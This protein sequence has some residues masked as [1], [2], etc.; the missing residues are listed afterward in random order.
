MKKIMTACITSALIFGSSVSQAA[1]LPEVVGSWL[2]ETQI[3]ANVRIA[4]DY[5]FY[6]ASQTSGAGGNKEGTSIQG[7]FDITWATLSILG[8][9]DVYSG[10]FAANTEWSRGTNDPASLEFTHYH[11]IAGG[12]GETGIS[13]DFGAIQYTYPNQDGDAGA[14]DD[15]DYWEYYGNF[16]YTFSDIM[17]E[18]SLGVGYYYSPA[19]FGF[20]DE[21][22]HV[23]VTLDLSLPHGFGINMFFGH[24]SLDFSA[25]NLAAQTG[26][27]ADDYQY[28]GIGISKSMFGVDVDASYT[29]ISSRDDCALV[30]TGTTAGSECGGFIFGV[31]KAF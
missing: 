31:S 21:S 14:T 1:D 3:A 27:Q 17:F 23:P 10:I 28:Y 24:L 12:L 16:G 2:D 11:G 8:G 5:Q 22:H 13:W 29:K 7:G 20:D 30:Q 26:G 18:P 19:W 9:I 6:G 15:F 25:A 4:N